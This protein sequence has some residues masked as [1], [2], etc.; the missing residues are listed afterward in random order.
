MAVV[1]VMHGADDAEPAGLGGQQWKSIADSQPGNSRVDVTELATNG[2]G[3]LGLGIER[4]VV[5]RA[6]VQEEHDARGVGPRFGCR[7]GQQ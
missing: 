6:A 1:A 5:R 2:L 3:G 4:L 7:G